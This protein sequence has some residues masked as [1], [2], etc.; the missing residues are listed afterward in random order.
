MSTKVEAKLSPVSVRALVV[1]LAGGGIALLLVLAQLTIPIPGT[2]VVTDPREIFTT[3]GAGFSGPVGGLLVG[4]LA[5]VAEPGIP[6]ASLLAHI[7]GGLW[8]GLAYKKLVYARLKMPV[9]LLG[10]AALVLIYYYVFAITGFALGQRLFYP[11]DFVQYYGANASVLDA[12]AALA[13]GVVTEALLTT[14]ITTLVMVALPE[15]YR[16][17]LW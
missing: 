3:L 13:Q 14:L 4:I 8:M 15:K 1:A 12:Y 10:W 17:P 7:A 5:G 2:G 11:A 6:L 9:R 16:R